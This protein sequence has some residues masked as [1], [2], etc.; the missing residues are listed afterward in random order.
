MS[1]FVKVRLRESEEFL[2]K[3]ENEIVKYCKIK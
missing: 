2:Q 3:P 1:S